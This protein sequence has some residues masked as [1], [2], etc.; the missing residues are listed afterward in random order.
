M[1]MKRWMMCVVS[2]SDSVDVVYLA[3]CVYDA[4]VDAGGGVVN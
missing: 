2:Q 4:D 1:A 3:V